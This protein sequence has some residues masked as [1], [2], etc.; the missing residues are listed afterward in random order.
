MRTMALT[1]FVAAVASGC[2]VLKPYEKEY[3]L[4]P[5]M[6]DDHLGGIDAS[7]MISATTTYEKLGKGGSGAGGGSACP[8][9]GG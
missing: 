2:A 7:L 6:D 5:A 4:N 9:C 8:T 3:L 1:L